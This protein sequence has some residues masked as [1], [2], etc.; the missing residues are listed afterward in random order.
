M[1]LETAAI[2]G[3][4][5]AATSA[6]GAGMSFAQAARE[7]RLRRQAM[8]D[9][10]KAMEEA[11]RAINVNP[12]E[13]LNVPMLPYQLQREALTQA[14]AQAMEAAREGTRG[15]GA[16]AMAGRVLAQS[17]QSQGEIAS[18]QA[19]A[20]YALE[21]A[22]ADKEASIQKELANLSL[23]EVEGAQTAARDAEKLRA[24]AMSQGMS[25][26]GDLADQLVEKPELFKQDRKTS[27][28]D[29]AKSNFPNLASDPR[30]SWL[31]VEQPEKP[32]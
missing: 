10:A 32:Q 24:L 15:A 13:A 31:F 6:A 21:K 30:W 29:Y 2:L 4:A 5:S 23:A 17:Q 1:G 14:S 18:A 28:P 11:K 3:I 7:S 16:G 9:A 20:L 19:E 26:M 25:Q 12:Y 27:M 22:K 8:D